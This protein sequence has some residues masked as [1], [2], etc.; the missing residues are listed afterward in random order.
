MEDYKITEDTFQ[1]NG[2]VKIVHMGDMI[3]TNCGMDTIEVSL[4]DINALLKGEMWVYD[5][6]EYVHLL[7]MDKDVKEFFE[8]VIEMACSAE[9]TVKKDTDSGITF[10]EEIRHARVCDQ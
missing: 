9:K 10:R 5:D 7:R 6:G 2:S 1:Y 8:K 4:E 3:D